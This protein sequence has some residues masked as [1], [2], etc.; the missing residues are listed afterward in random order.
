MVFGIPV[1][2]RYRKMLRFRT[3]LL[4]GDQ[5]D[6]GINFVFIP[7]ALECFRPV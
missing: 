5:C 7:F 4:S 1:F 2:R 6:V 3:H